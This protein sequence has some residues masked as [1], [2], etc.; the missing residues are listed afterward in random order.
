M[1]VIVLMTIVIFA[2]YL[3]SEAVQ[4]MSAETEARAAASD[5]TRLAM[6]RITRELRQTQ[7]VVEEA[8]GFD[9]NLP[10]DMRFFADIDG[11]DGPERIR[12]RVPTGGSVL[13]RTVEQP[14][15][16]IPPYVTTANPW[17]TPSADQ[18]MC[19]KI[20]ASA[21]LFKYY[22]RS[23]AVVAAG[24]YDTISAVQIRLR[25]AATVRGRTAY[26]LMES[27][28]TLRAVNSAVDP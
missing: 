14:S 22:D 12:Y 13:L 19:S 2:A 8:G 27:W 21:P 20:D 9:A 1:I 18:T 4:I 5:Q 17:G 28:L 10:T 23:D 11:D 26:V 15:S 24:T 7:E 16:N 25:N 6:D 3:L